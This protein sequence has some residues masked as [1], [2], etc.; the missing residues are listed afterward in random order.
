MLRAVAIWAGLAGVVAAAFASGASSELLAWRDA[1][2]IV[3]GF[4]G[5]AGLA[6]ILFQPLLAAGLLPGLG[7]REA[8]RAHLWLGVGLVAAILVHVVGL[9][10]TSPPDA[11]DALLFVSPT[12]FSPF[13]VIAMWASFATAGFAALRVAGRIR[14]R[15]WRLWHTAL[16]IVIVLCVCAHTL[17][18]EGPMGTLAKAALC[19]LAVAAMAKAA[20]DLRAWRLLRRRAE[21]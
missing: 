1:V 21:G 5:I 15:L 8:R 19:A 10:V 4:A 13:G 11:I 12:P 2:Y 16:A 3:A 14:P 6:I 20:F 7:L 9:I 17:L 18:V